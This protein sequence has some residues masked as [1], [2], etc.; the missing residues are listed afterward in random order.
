MKRSTLGV[1]RSKVK[2]TLCQSLIWRPGGGVLCSPFCF[3]KLVFIVH[4]T[5]IIT[6]TSVIKTDRTYITKLM[7][8][9]PYII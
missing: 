6:N 7:A 9:I 3:V 2:V 1:R 8:L 5:I 4:R